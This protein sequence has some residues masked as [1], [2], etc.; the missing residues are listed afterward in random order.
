[1]KT[2][3]LSS[4]FVLIGAGCSHTSGF[5]SETVPEVMVM[6]ESSARHHE[7][8][9]STITLVRDQSQGWTTM[10]DALLE[11]ANTRGIRY[12]SNLELQWFEIRDSEPLRCGAKVQ[13]R[14]F[15]PGPDKRGMAI[16]DLSRRKMISSSQRTIEPPNAAVNAPQNKA[17]TSTPQRVMIHPNNRV[18]TSDPVWSLRL[19]GTA[20]ASTPETPTDQVLLVATAY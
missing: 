9:P 20:C 4:I 18:G 16:S 19:E 14:L 2:I 13:P 8:T 17:N 6:T 15:L 10:V 12:L 7:G 1:M 3:I 11:R 5:R